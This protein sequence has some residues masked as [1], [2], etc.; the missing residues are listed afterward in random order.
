MYSID[1]D[2]T[3]STILLIWG[4][5]GR[6]C[7]LYRNRLTAFMYLTAIRRLK[8]AP[9]DIGRTHQQPPLLIP[10]WY[11]QKAT[12]DI[13][14]LETMASLR[15][16]SSDDRGQCSRSKNVCI[17]PGYFWFPNCPTFQLLTDPAPESRLKDA[18]PPHSLELSHLQST[19]H[20][21]WLAWG[22]LE[23]ILVLQQYNVLR[24]LLISWATSG[25]SPL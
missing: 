13:G 10:L 2:G 18:T 14:K 5:Y 23:E 11:Y 16:M 17:S 7:S 6:R 15:C 3:T 9:V 24:S 19:D 20:V 25:D 4:D 21:P 22:A 1:V 12:D 8:G